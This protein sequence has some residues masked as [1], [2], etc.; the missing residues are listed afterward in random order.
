MS[1]TEGLKERADRLLACADPS[2]C[3]YLGLITELVRKKDASGIDWQGYVG[4]LYDK[5]Y[6]EVICNNGPPRTRITFGTSGWR[7]ILGKDLFCTSVAQVTQA[8]VEMYHD[9][10]KSAD[11]AS[12]L[13]VADVDE[14]KK[15]GCV[16]GFDNRFG[17]DVFA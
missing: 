13:G 6:E 11:L 14:A 16:I 12:A 3:D 17:G 4:K 9:L 8:I 10:G 2:S 15:R 7:G 1:P 5:V